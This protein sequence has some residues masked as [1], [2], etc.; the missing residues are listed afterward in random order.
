MRDPPS[1]S[2]IVKTVGKPALGARTSTGEGDGGVPAASDCD[3]QYESGKRD[4]EPA[5][6]RATTCL[7]DQRLEIVMPWVRRRRLEPALPRR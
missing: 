5:A 2:H 4:L 3:Q 7:L 6:A 1:G